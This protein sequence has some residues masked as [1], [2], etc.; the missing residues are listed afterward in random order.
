MYN[1]EVSLRMDDPDIILEY[2]VR[3]YMIHNSNYK[4]VKKEVMIQGLWICHVNYI[5][6]DYDIFVESLFN[7]RKAQ[8]SGFVI[9]KTK[10]T[11]IT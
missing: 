7:L 4:N 6:V 10:K 8:K 2:Y 3:L 11:K 9:T 1:Y 5:R